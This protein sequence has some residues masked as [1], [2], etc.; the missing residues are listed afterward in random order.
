M[1]LTPA[2]A[3]TLMSPLSSLGHGWPTMPLGIIGG[4]ET[5]GPHFAAIA[6]LFVLMV[7]LFAVGASHQNLHKVTLPGLFLSGIVA[8]LAIAAA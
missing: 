6:S 3:L 4:S 8:A 1:N 2:I 5:V 7:I